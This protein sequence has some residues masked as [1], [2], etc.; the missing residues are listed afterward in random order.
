MSGL[1]SLLDL[2]AGAFTAQN[3]GIAVAGRNT[4]NVNTEGYQREQIDLESEPASPLV[5]GVRSGDPSRL[6]DQLLARRE[7]EAQA[8]FGFSD[9][10]TNALQGLEKDLTNS[11]VSDAT[12][13]FFGALSSLA[14]APSDTASR[15]AVVSAAQQLATTFNDQ[16]TSIAN[17]RAD[18]NGRI[19]SMAQQA[20]QYAAQIAAANKA[21]SASDDPVLAD[22]R[23]LAG[24]KLA[25]LTGG[26]ARIDPD[27]QMRVVTSSGAT[28]VDGQRAAQVQTAPDP[29]DATRV[30]VN[31]VDG[32]HVD[33]ITTTVGGRIGGEVSFRDGAAAQA[34]TDLD[35]LA[36]AVATQVNAVH[37]TYAGLDGVA[38]RNLFQ[39]V[40]GPGAAAAM[41]VNPTVVADPRQLASATVGLGQ[42]DNAGIL[43]LLALR[44]QPLAGGGTRSF[45]DEAIHLVGEVG[46]AAA[47]SS[48]QQSV[49]SSRV[50]AL[51][52]ARD[53]VS[54]VST[55]EE[56]ASLAQFQHASEAAQQFV[57]VVNTLLDDLIKNV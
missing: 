33:D 32:T 55:N 2:G 26:A 13:N 57:S 42:G 35:S 46:A 16:A 20:T 41:A 39:P 19:A 37:A 30:L 7:R 8:S 52:S 23:D 29:N 24:K 9:S 54:G 12:A 15:T 5:G 47:S 28:L 31:V 40:A 1:L 56:M 25:E 22:Q 53:A 48:S 50:D 49:D 3:A 10:L 11:G 34:V 51:A 18:S 43:A 45:S 36:T 44:D 4:A 21:L 27:G 17:A 6:G 14:E 38:G